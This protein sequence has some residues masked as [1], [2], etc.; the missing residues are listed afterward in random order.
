MFCHLEFSLYDEVNI[1]DLGLSF[2]VD[3]FSSVK[4]NFFHVMED[5]SD[6]IGPQTSQNSVVTQC[7]N[8]LL[9]LT[10]LLLANDDAVIISSQVG[11]ICVFS[12]NDCSAAPL[13]ILHSQVA[14]AL[15]NLKRAYCLEPSHLY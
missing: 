10:T 1:V 3:D 13:M 12:T 5:L 15:A 7:L 8:N 9:H 4:L 6:D 2:F 14:E 11:Q